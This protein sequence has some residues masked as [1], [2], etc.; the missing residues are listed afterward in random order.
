[1]ILQTN[2]HVRRLTKARPTWVMENANVLSEVLII[3]SRLLHNNRLAYLKFV[4]PRASRCFSDSLRQ[5][6]SV[7]SA[8]SVVEVACLVRI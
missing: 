4:A 3:T 1:M 8:I 2:L 5:V 7:V 6:A